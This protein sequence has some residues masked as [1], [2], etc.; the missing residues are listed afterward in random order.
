MMFAKAT[1][2]NRKSGVAE[3]YAVPRADHSGNVFRQSE[4]LSTLLPAQ[5]ALLQSRESILG[6]SCSIND[7][8]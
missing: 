4:P 3:G 2:F 1:K 7:P 6:D 8:E 5:Q